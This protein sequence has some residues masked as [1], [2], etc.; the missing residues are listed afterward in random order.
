MAA[1][2]LLLLSSLF[3][4]CQVTAA[5]DLGEY[6]Y[7]I[8]PTLFQCIFSYHPFF[9]KFG[10]LNPVLA[11]LIFF[12][13]FYLFSFSKLKIILKNNIAQNESIVHFSKKNCVFKDFL[14][15]RENTKKTAILHPNFE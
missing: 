8:Q 1:T 9:F 12:C 6:T 3:V 5:K 13:G 10:N 4:A 2:W 15:I 11:V 14:L 7:Y